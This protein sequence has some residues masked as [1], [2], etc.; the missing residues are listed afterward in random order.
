MLVHFFVKDKDQ[1][2]TEL[3]K[4]GRYKP[5]FLELLLLNIGNGYVQFLQTFS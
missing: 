2:R 4:K 5:L 1:F 3:F